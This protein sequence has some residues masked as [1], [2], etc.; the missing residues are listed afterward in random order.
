MGESSTYRC[1]NCGYTA[2]VAG[3]R[4]CGFETVV[5][6]ILCRDCR[7]LYDA[8][9]EERAQDVLMDDGRVRGNLTEIRCP[10]SADH[11]FMRWRKPWPC[12]KCGAVMEAVGPVMPWD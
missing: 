6:T 10:R 8:V 2:L 7:E 3:G 4:A 12:P 5:E 1:P 11:K 9:A